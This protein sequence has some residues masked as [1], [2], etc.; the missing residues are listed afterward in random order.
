MS[1]PEAHPSH[2]SEGAASLDPGEG[3]FRPDSR[4]SRDLGV[5]LL[6]V[7]ATM[8]PEGSALTVLD[9]L[10]GC[11][12]RSLRY[13]LEAGAT[14]VLSNDADPQ[15]RPLLERNLAPLAA[16]GVT[17][18]V[19]TTTIQKLLARC[20]LEE[21]RFDWVDLDAFGG[22]TELLPLAIEA[23]R[24]D[25]VLY[26]ASTDGRSFTGHDRRAAVRRLGAAVRAQP[27]SWE[28]ALRLQLGA[29][30]RVAWSQGRGIRPL[31]SLSD[32]RTF[33]TAVAI[34]RHPAAGEESQLGLTGYC[35]GCGDHRGASLLQLRPGSL[36]RCACGG[37]P[38]LSGPLWRGPLQDCSWLR[39]ADRQAPP[40]T[41]SSA[42]RRRLEQLA[43]DAG[44]PPE[45][46]S[47]GDL[48]RRL[49]LGPPPLAVLLERLREAGWQAGASGVAAGQFRTDA[50]WSAVLEA[51][52]QRH[53]R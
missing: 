45:A 20:L 30:A 19:Q 25:G 10:A 15:R 43:D 44:L 11:G 13:G 23:V 27:C 31:L 36:G 16:R 8:R 21:R 12:I 1:T 17:V 35:H 41:L 46:W 48:A 5:A 39:A 47:Q 26:L 18:E 37:E 51:G 24:F 2:Y 28:L 7:L 3:F 53:S 42:S 34:R 33:R 9:G 6:H 14:A 29:V 52:G 40:G 4:P 22:S 32:G 50:P 49:G 38:V